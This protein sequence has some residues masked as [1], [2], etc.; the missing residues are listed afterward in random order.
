MI[1]YDKYKS[2]PDGYGIGTDKIRNW[3]VI[4]IDPED[5]EV[6]TYWQEDGMRKLECLSRV[7][8][9]MNGDGGEYLDKGYKFFIEPLKP[10]ALDYLED[11]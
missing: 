8:T 4:V 6:V 10:M 3:L 9:F 1:R 11:K 2:W 7:T 5:E